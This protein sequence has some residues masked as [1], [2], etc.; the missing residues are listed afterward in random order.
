MDIQLRN[1]TIRDSD[2]L[3]ALAGQLGYPSTPSQIQRRLK[4][5]L[6]SEGNTVIVAEMPET[7]IAGWVHVYTQTYVEDDY[8]AEI[9]GLVVADGFRGQGVGRRLM[10]SA[11]AWAREQGCA[12]MRLRSN[13]IREQAHQFYRNQG[14]RVFKTS[15]TFIKDL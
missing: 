5:L 13:I 15:L 9:G 8:H 10:E 3:A 1:A 2:A 14:Y 4:A 6:A 7:G 11:E 12:L